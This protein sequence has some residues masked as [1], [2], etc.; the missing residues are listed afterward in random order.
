MSAHQQQSHR[1]TFSGDCACARVALIAP[2]TGTSHPR[3]SGANCRLHPPPD[4]RTW[5]R[6][7]TGG[8]SAQLERR[9]GELHSGGTQRAPLRAGDRTGG[10]WTRGTPGE[11]AKKSPLKTIAEECGGAFARLWVCTMLNK[12]VEEE[13]QHVNGRTHTH[14]HTHT[15]LLNQ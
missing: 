12:C 7:D 3:G 4:L 15:Q 10:Q 9:R 13:K 1:T 2:H 11:T 8:T 5:Q 6:A 14:T